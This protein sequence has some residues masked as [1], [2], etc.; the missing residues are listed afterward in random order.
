MFEISLTTGAQKKGH[1]RTRGW[2]STSH[3]EVSLETYFDGTS[4]FLPTELQSICAFKLLKKKRKKGKYQGIL[5]INTDI[6]LRI[7]WYK[8]SDIKI[9]NQ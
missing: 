3:H 6:Y 5:S 8:L 2:Q 7:I 1:L 9:K 4:I